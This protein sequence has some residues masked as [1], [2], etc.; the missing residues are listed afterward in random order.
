MSPI[1]F[2]KGSYGAYDFEHNVFQSHLKN[3]QPFKEARV[4][5]GPILTITKKF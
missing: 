2:L 4:L 3:H 5:T 1:I